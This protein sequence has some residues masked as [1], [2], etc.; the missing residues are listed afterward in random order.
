MAE[1]P[2]LVRAHPFSSD[3]GLVYASSGQTIGQMLRAAAG[4]GRELAPLEVRIGGYVVPAELWDRLRPK[5]G[6][7][8]EVTGLPQGNMNANWRAVLM[9]VVTIAVFAYTGYLDTNGASWALSTSQWGTVAMM[10]SSAAIPP[11]IRPPE[12]PA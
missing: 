4:E 8:I 2:L 5:E 6:A 12:L 1:I 9:I 11:S 10:A 7:Q 3:P